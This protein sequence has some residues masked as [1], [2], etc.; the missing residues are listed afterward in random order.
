MGAAAVALSPAETRPAPILRE[1]QNIFANRVAELLHRLRLPR[2]R[3]SAEEREAIFRLR[4]EGLPSGRRDR[5][6]RPARSPTLMTISRTCASS[7]SIFDGELA[8]SIRIHVTSPAHADFP[9]YLCVRGSARSGARR[10]PRDRRSDPL[11]HHWG[12]SQLNPGLPYATL[13]L[14]WLA[15]EHFRA[16]H[17]LVAIRSEHQAFYRR[18]FRPSPD[19]RRAALSAARQADQPD[20]RERRRGGRAGVPA[21]S[22]LPLHL[23]RAAACCSNSSACRAFPR[24]R[25]CC[26]SIATGRPNSATRLDRRQQRLRTRR[27]PAR[28][29]FWIKRRRGSAFD[30]NCRP[31]CSFDRHATRHVHD[32][33]AAQ[34][35]N[36]VIRNRRRVATARRAPPSEMPMPRHQSNG[37]TRYRSPRAAG[38]C[39]V[40]LALPHRT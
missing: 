23:L 1:P 21:L 37:P 31:I 32:I 40:H 26:I 4:Y 34:A 19:L 14:C 15:S 2:R 38:V 7:G 3:A 12:A 8:S 16:E 9:S 6:R 20:D 39:A 24:K 18:T 17:F 35:D 27:E 28:L 22:V 11:R 30:T 29:S 5:A 13:R 33:I 36:A 10:R 25:R